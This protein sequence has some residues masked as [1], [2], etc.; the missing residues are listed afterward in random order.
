MIMSTA[1]GLDERVLSLQER[2]R[3]E[4]PRQPRPRNGG[5]AA[6]QT[7][8]PA[9]PDERLAEGLG[10]FSIGL[11][12]AQI[13]A[14]ASLSR[15]IGV[16]AD[17]TN[18]TLMQVLGVRELATGIGIL[19][20]PHRAGWVGA[21][22]AGDT[23]D[24]A[25]LG[26]ALTSPN[27]RKDRVELATTAVAGITLLDAYCT[28]Q[29]SRKSEST[30]ALPTRRP[31]MNVRQRVTVNRPVAE[32]YGFWRQLE[33]LPRFMNHLESVTVTGGGRSHWKA[34]APAGT[35]VEWDAEMV[36]DLPNERISWRSVEGS[37]VNNSGSVRFKAAPGGR[38]T[39]VHVELQYDAPGGKLG[40]LIA[41]LFG[42][43]P[44]QQVNDDLRAFKQVM[45]TGEVVRSEGSLRGR[46]PQHA[47]QPAKA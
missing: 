22:V 13:L 29:L 46:Y 2:T 30:R 4:M 15:L 7:R 17:A 9:D 14:P 38:G 37:D 1:A 24:L 18:R 31:S 43:E 33:N 42:Q 27:S 41:K 8:R 16:R 40:A 23:M 32:V 34:K 11:G 3:H 12:L 28:E 39:E 6:G 45:E 47:A 10:W 35:S 44:S 26:L 36:E 20:R 21:R 19:T 25:L 5:L